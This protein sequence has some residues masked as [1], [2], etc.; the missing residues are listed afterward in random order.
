[1]IRAIENEKQKP[2]KLGSVLSNS[3]VDRGHVGVCFNVHRRKEK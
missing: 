2:G 3:S 1:M